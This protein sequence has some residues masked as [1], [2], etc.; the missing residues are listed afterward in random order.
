[1]KK[2]LAP[3]V[4]ALSTS[5]TFAQKAES[6]VTPDTLGKLEWIQGSAPTAWEPGK[7]YVIECWATWCGP[8]L[9]AIPHVDALYDKYQDKGLRVIGV[10]VWEDGK[11]KVA[12]F[13]KGKGEGMSYPV[14]YT[15]KGGAFETEWLIP[16]EVKGI[17]HSFVVKDG[18]VLLTT[19][20]AQLT[21]EVIEGLLAG[22]DSQDK[23][24]ESIKAEQKKQE[25]LSKTMQAFQMASSKKDAAGME[26]AIEDLKA[27][28]A[29]SRYLPAMTFDVLIAKGD[30]AGA[31]ANLTTLA[32]NPMRPMILMQTA[33]KAVANADV[34]ESFRKTLV[35]ELSGDMEKRKAGP[36]EYQTLARL[37]WS[38]GDKE[39]ATASANLAEEGA[40]AAVA[41]NPKFPVAPFEK[42]AAKVKGGEMP[43]SEE[44]TQWLR[45]AMPAQQAA[46]AKAVTPPVSA[47]AANKASE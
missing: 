30:W 11:D 38:V 26:K 42:F 14:A 1:M 28:D 13:V 22:G 31:E 41:Q 43:T 16:A 21:E 40:K 5:A 2:T 12:D 39:A 8:C 27:L 24:L 19:H 15:G 37:Q 6:T 18:K 32:E 34:P 45:E 25:D 9:A 29:D 17:P 46:P 20:P 35:K 44:T 23:A 47:T 3:L 36:F 7:L 33:A 10:D 4:L